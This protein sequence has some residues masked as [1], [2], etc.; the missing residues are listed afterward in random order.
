MNSETSTPDLPLPTKEQWQ[1]MIT[2]YVEHKGDRKRSNSDRYSIKGIATEY[3][4]ICKVSK[5]SLHRYIHD[6]AERSCVPVG[7]PRSLGAAELFELQNI[8]LQEQSSVSGN[9]TE[10]RMS[11]TISSLARTSG[12]PFKGD[13]P[14]KRTVKKY[15]GEI[16][17]LHT[18]R[19]IPTS[20]ARMKAACDPKSMAG[21]FQ[22]IE[23]ILE[24]YPQLR[25]LP[26]NWGNSDESGFDCKISGT[27]LVYWI[28]DRGGKRFKKARTVAVSDGSNHVTVECMQLGDGHLL[29]NAYI[30]KGDNVQSS[31]LSPNESDSRYPYLPNCSLDHML[32]LYL[33]SSPAGM[34]DQILF[35]SLLAEHFYP[36]WRAY[37][38][39]DEPLVHNFDYPECHHFTPELLRAMETYN[40]RVC[41]QPHN[42]STIVQW[43]DLKFFKELKSNMR[44]TFQSLAS[45]LADSHYYLQCTGTGQTKLTLARHT[46]SEYA[47]LPDWSKRIEC[48]SR[49]LAVRMNPRTIIQLSEYVF[50]TYLRPH[51]ELGVEAC[52]LSGILPFNPS[53]VLDAMTPEDAPAMEDVR[54]SAR[55]VDDETV[56]SLLRVLNDPDSTSRYKILQAKAICS[57]ARDSSEVILEGNDLSSE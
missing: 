20:E 40:V 56:A 55:L 22:E 24:E 36:L 52:R 23:D 29:P 35:G 13:L 53:L 27:K 57:Q 48:R 15:A 54:R 2:E 43:L 14:D 9:I 6:G 8:V 34:V 50:Q 30:V 39:N 45:V 21:F 25:S 51:P 5:S 46:P 1:A 42:G 37:V 26:K 3:G 4:K 18:A 33:C 12:R 41:T 38:Q 44:L 31:W 7:R 32:Q 16:P 47:R 10:D 49:G 11:A 19:A 28:E 17:N